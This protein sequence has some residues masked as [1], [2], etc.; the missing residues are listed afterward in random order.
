[1]LCDV[2]D[3]LGPGLEPV[4]PA[5][6]GGLLTTVPPGQ[7][8]FYFILF[9]LFIFIFLKFILFIFLFLAAL[10]FRCCTRAFSSCSGGG[11]TLRCGAQ[12]SHC[13]GFSC[14][15]ARALGAWASVV[16]AHGL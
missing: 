10:G 8:L 12:A 16:V 3:L 5:L 9:Y 2:W 1:M 6:V 4:S 13:G 11:A 15:G 14:C 7:S